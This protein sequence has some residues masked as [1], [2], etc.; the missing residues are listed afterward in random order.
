MA[1]SQLTPLQITRRGLMILHQKLN[2]I[3]NVNRQ[4][5]DRF[6]ETGAKIGQTLNI[7]M[8]AKYTTGSGSTISA[9]Q[10]HVERSTPLTV[11]SQT[12]IAASWT[13]LELTM[14]LD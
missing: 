12:W 10:D 13:T 6:A 9:Y 11:S 14:E 3:G 1:N 4:Y 5:D 2:F 7:R 8:P